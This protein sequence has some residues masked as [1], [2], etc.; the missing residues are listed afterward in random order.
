MIKAFCE[1]DSLDSHSQPLVQYSHRLT[2]GIASSSLIV[3][4][5]E[6]SKKDELVALERVMFAV[7]LASWISSSKIGTLKV[8][9]VWP[10]EIIKEPDVAV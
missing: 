7:S 9:E 1:Y 8:P 4:I 5:A 6:S 3:S 2:V 10:A